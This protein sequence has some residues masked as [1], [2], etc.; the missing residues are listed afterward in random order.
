MK[1]AIVAFLVSLTASVALG[2]DDAGGAAPTAPTLTANYSGSVLFL[3]VAD[4]SL[5]AV[6]PDQTYS[7]AARFTTAGIAAWFD[8]T[9]I[10]A[11]VSGYRAASALRPWRYEHLN[12]ASSKN[13]IVGIDFP[14]GTAMPDINPPFGSMG[15]PPASDTDRAGAIDP[16]TT[17]LAI[18]SGINPN[19]AR[20][21]GANEEGACEG[22]FP[23][24]DGKARYDVRLEAGGRDRVRTSAWRGQALVCRAYLEPISGYDADDRPDA[25]ETAEPVTMWLAPVDGFWVPVRF[26]ARTEIGQINIRAQRIQVQ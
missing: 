12:H 21:G 7:A 15:E 22:R 17:L 26:R 13:R 8:D 23:V 9:D 6:F 16:L 24:F 11:G 14:D 19:G 2:D 25:G 5:S 20:P 1:T 4:I 10:E 3:P 18:I